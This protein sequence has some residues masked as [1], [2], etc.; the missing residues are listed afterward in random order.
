MEVLVAQLGPTLCDPMDCSPPLSLEFSGQEYWSGLPFPTP[1]DLPDPEI[2]LMSPASPALA[3]RLFTTEP[4]GKPLGGIQF[5]SV[6]T[7]IRV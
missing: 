2:K 5:S 6:Q 7:L 3:G 4:P 1:R